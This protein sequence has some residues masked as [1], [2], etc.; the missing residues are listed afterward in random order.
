AHS[1]ASSPAGGSFSLVSQA[2][3]SAGAGAHETSLE[4]MLMA[5]S[6]LIALIGIALAYIF[7]LKNQDLPRR[8]TARFARLYH[9]VHN[10]YFVDEFYEL[11]FV[12][13]ILKVGALLLKAVDIGLIEGLVN[14]TAAVIQR[15]GAK[16][17]RIETG[18]VQQYAFGIILGAIVVVGY[19]IVIPMF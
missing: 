17:R 9:V 4:I 19:L 6:V 18:Y 5:G 2:W 1:A 8:F 3:A 13:G 11:L 15:A 10:K 12:R 14:G 16:L 7:Y